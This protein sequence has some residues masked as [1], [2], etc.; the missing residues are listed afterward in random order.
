MRVRSRIPALGALLLLCVTRTAAGAGF[1]AEASVMATYTGI[2]APIEIENAS[3]T[4][5]SLATASANQPIDQ[6]IEGGGVLY[7]NGGLIELSS[8]ATIG[9][10]A[11]FATATLTSTETPFTPDGSSNGGLV[12]AVASAN[13][14]DLLTV[15]GPQPAGTPVSITVGIRLDATASSDVASQCG[16]VEPYAPAGASLFLDYGDFP[17]LQVQSGGC[18]PTAPDATASFD[19]TIGALFSITANLSAGINFAT[20]SDVLA[21]NEHTATMDA[22]H[23]GTIYISSPTPGVGVSAESGFVYPVPEPGDVTAWAAAIG[24]LGLLHRTRRVSVR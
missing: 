9:S 4:Q 1:Q 2:G 8:Q 16:G 12:N 10:L 7:E 23:T 11:A 13:F 15:I 5:P 22:S 18:T 6:S 17:V 24:V 19:T 14:Q 3:G 20:N 21:D